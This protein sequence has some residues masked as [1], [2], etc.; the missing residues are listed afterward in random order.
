MDS[1]GCWSIDCNTKVTKVD[2]LY[3]LNGGAF[4]NT[5]ASGVTAGDGQV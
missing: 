3:N 4:D 5:I 1:N 2:V